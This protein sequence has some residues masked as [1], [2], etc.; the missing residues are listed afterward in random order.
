MASIE[1][2]VT[3]PEE[4][5]CQGDG[6]FRANVAALVVRRVARGFEI[7]L[8]SRVN[9]SGAWQCPQGGIDPGET[10][11]AALHRELREEIGVSRIHVHRQLPT[12]LRYRFPA[13]LGQRF[14][15]NIG[16]EQRY[17]IVTLDPDDPPDLAKAEEK[18]FNALKWAPLEQALDA[19]IWFKRPVIKEALSQARAILPTLDL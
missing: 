9:A 14:K 8:G 7:L 1:P 13:T 16:Q 17:F 2:A 11:L 19:A 10:P 12:M 3:R 18:E 6:P 4:P 15:P 5:L